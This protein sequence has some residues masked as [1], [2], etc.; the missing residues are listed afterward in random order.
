MRDS[1]KHIRLSFLGTFLFFFLICFT[2]VWGH[3]GEA[4]KEDNYPHPDG[5]CFDFYETAHKHSGQS[6]DKY[7]AIFCDEKL[8]EISEMNVTQRAGILK[9]K[10]DELSTCLDNIVNPEV[11]TELNEQMRKLR[12]EIIIIGSWGGESADSA[13]SFFGKNSKTIPIDSKGMAPDE[14][15][16]RA[17]L[18]DP[19]TFNECGN[20]PTTFNECVTKK[21]DEIIETNEDIKNAIHRYNTVISQKS[22]YDESKKKCDGVQLYIDILSK[23]DRGSTEEIEKSNISE[24]CKKAQHKARTCCDPHLGMDCLL[25]VKNEDPSLMST[26]SNAAGSDWFSIIQATAPIVKETMGVNASCSVLEMSAAAGATYNAA[27]GKMCVTKA[28]SCID[29][30]EKDKADP[31]NEKHKKDYDSAISSCKKHASTTLR[32]VEKALTT[33]GTAVYHSRNCGDKTNA[34]PRPQGCQSAY[35]M[36]KP[37]CL[38]WCQNTNGEDPLCSVNGP[39]KPSFGGEQARGGGGLD[40][41]PLDGLEDP[42][43][44]PVRSKKTESGASPSGSQGMGGLGGFGG[45]G[46]SPSS[47]ND[48]G[49]SSL[50]GDPEEIGDGF[51]SSGKFNSK[52]RP[53]YALFPGGDEGSGTNSFGKKK[54]TS[55]DPASKK[56]KK[57][58]GRRSSGIFD[59]I[60]KGYHKVCKKGRLNANCKGMTG[61]RR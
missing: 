30:C 45:F 36:Q 24:D 51:V 19:T 38:N 43:L 46:G 3:V 56:L 48:K 50:G 4:G 2:D 25:N 20:N 13:F 10:A 41:D 9:A 12:E 57:E 52:T 21:I 27:L 6:N 39:I 37:A 59:T 17:G 29:V 7:D 60:H 8:E 44:P 22:D 18:F 16:P 54:K 61:K 53:G 55:R 33:A 26:I 31:K 42:N 14:G 1:F 49:D 34:F 28:N 11:Q 23:Y 40:Y 58:L 47:S 15:D 32:I 5:K 35:D